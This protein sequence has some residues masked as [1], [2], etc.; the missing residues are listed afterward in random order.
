MCMC[1]C[2]YLGEGS[3]FIALGTALF[4]IE[5]V[6]YNP[7]GCLLDATS[8]WQAK[9]TTVSKESSNRTQKIIPNSHCKQ[10]SS[11]VSRNFQL[12]TT[13]HPFFEKS[14]V[15]DSFFERGGTGLIILEGVGGSW[16]AMQQY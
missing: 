6:A 3:W 12:Q 4:T 14:G 13:M 16:E 11:I 7:S 2:L 10:K 15:E 9:N 8:D 1:S 5:L